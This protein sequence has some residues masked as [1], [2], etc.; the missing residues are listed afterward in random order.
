M[1]NRDCY[2]E[3]REKK[4]VWLYSSLTVAIKMYYK[5]NLLTLDST[6]CHDRYSSGKN[7]AVVGLLIAHDNKCLCLSPTRKVHG[8]HK[9]HYILHVQGSISWLYCHCKEK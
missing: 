5:N 6:L 3:K 7:R 1:C 9:A 4:T 8:F 2:K